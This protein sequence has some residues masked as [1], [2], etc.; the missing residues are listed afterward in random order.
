MTYRTEVAP[1][2][3]RNAS[4]ACDARVAAILPGI[5]G[6]LPS[7]TLAEHIAHD[8]FAALD[9]RYARHLSP[10]RVDTQTRTWRTVDGTDVEIVVQWVK[11]M[12]PNGT[13][14]WVTVGPGGAIVEVERES[15]WDYPAGRRA[16][17]QWDHDG[18]IAAR[19]GTGPQLAAPN[20]F[21]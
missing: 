8:V 3:L 6:P 12:H 20:A 4:E 7:P 1:I 15:H 21:A 13:Y 11:H 9:P 14:N 5:T 19:E 16:T 10:M 17:E 2:P 18:W